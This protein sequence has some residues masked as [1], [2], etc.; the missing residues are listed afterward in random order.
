MNAALVLQLAKQDLLDRYAGSMLGGFWT[1][2]QPLLNMLVFILVFSQIMQA[3]LPAATAGAHSYSVY[4]IAGLLG[5]IAFSSTLLRTTTMFID[6]GG[7]IKKVPLE[8]TVFPLAIVLSDTVVFVISFG[9]F[10]LYLLIISHPFTPAMLWVPVAFALQQAFA[11]N[12]GIVLGALSVFYRDIK[13]GV[14]VLLQ[15]WFWLTPIVYVVEIL[16]DWVQ[17]L[18]WLNPMYPIVDTYHNAVLFGEVTAPQRLLP[19]LVVAALLFV[20]GRWLLRRLESDIRDL[21]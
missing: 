4:L 14:S 2:V 1:F 11:V 8:L 9:L 15:L 21:V 12:L 13:E 10:S 18:L 6:Q 19:L 7:L 20:A 5:W 16:P 17:Q 3:R